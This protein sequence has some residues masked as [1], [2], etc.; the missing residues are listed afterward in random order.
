[1]RLTL[2]SVATL[3]AGA[4]LGAVAPRAARAQGSLAVGAHAAGTADDASTR[5]AAGPIAPRA[6][7]LT[8]LLIAH[9]MDLGLTDAQVT[10]LS[11]VAART[12]LVVSPLEAEIDSLALRG[13]ATDWARVTDEQGAILRAQV[14]KRSA[15]V[16]A[17]HDELMLARAQALDALTETQQRA[18][19]E[20]EVAERKAEAE[21]LRVTRGG[22]WNGVNQRP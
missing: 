10:R 8:T 3:I 1:M 7:R 21:R 15:L 22:G 19:V 2:V 6:P 13:D 5:V 12:D 11:A 18:A 4:S 17:V 14:R 20:L 16:A 9:R